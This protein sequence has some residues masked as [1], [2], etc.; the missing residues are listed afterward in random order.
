MC[1]TV[2]A[3]SLQLRVPEGD[4][5]DL[6]HP[7]GLS[8]TSW[9]TCS[10]LNYIFQS[11][12]FPEGHLREREV[13][14]TSIVCFQSGFFHGKESRGGPKVKQKKASVTSVIPAIG[15]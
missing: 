5:P 11:P 10:I 14:S 8:R 12:R 1:L 4:G 6:N 7:S 15:M 2:T 3:L 9:Q 13:V